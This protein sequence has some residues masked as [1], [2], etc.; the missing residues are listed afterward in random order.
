MVEMLM[1]WGQVRVLR[2]VM[3]I[4]GWV[5][6]LV[7]VVMLRWF[8]LMRLSRGVRKAWRGRGRSDVTNSVDFGNYFY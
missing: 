5:M 7:V 1:E 8:R 4:L 2:M 3:V 6:V